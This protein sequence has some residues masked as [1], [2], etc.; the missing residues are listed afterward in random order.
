MTKDNQAKTI[1][2]FTDWY[3]PGF[4]AGGPIQSVFNLAELLSKDFHVKV[5][6]RNTDLNS[7]QAYQNVLFDQWVSI[8]KQHEVLYIS[9]EKLGFKVI[10][11]II[12]EN[13]NNIILINGLFSFYFSF[14]PALLCISFPVRK[15]F[16]AVRGM[17]HTSALSVKP[18]KKQLFLTFARGLGLY[19][20]P[21]MLA[22]NAE[23]I[24]EIKKSLGK[25][26]PVIAPNIPMVYEDLKPS[27]E[28]DSKL[29]TLAFIGRIAPEKNPLI[30][31]EALKKI[32]NP[33]RVIFCGDSNNESYLNSFKEQ[34]SALPT[35]IN[36]EYHAEM[37]HKDIQNLLP[38]I[39]VMALPSLGENFGH[40][41][42]ESLVAGVPVIIGNNT[43]WKNMENKLAGIE[44]DPKDATALKDAVNRF[45]T[46]NKADFEQWRIAANKVAF[47]YNSA[48]NF[49][50][51]YLDLF[52]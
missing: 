25:V 34:L 28:R 13:T 21:V 50:Q 14:L 3:V 39:D 49:R 33:L 46:M 8:G 37:S 31:I 11:Q 42:Y 2:I 52:S 5:V 51:I 27:V 43:P 24:E 18:L 10:K 35:H 1:V 26:R 22:T 40:A 4:K 23:E 48:N 19:Q 12:K 20:K 32:Q 16:I 36:Y 41:I 29:F 38:E 47:D 6:S 30:L 9:Q 45:M 15:V 7:N 17:L 44:I